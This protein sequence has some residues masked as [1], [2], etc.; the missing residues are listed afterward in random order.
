MREARDAFRACQSGSQ[1]NDWGHGGTAALTIA[2][3]GKPMT[4]PMAR[5][6][7]RSAQPA[8]QCPCEPTLP[9]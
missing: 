5:S 7:S 8:T 4:P 1:A 6:K 9:R 3:S 2:P